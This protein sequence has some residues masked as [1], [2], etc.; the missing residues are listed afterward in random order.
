[1]EIT[2]PERE[3]RDDELR[4]VAEARVEE[5]ADAGPRVLGGMLG[6]LADQPRERN[7][8]DRGEHEERHVARPG[9]LV[10]RDREGCE[11]ERPP[12]ELAVHGALP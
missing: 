6:R 5:P 11:E 10:H 3:E 9:E 2:L 12:Q 4:R 1:L 7:Q 8:G